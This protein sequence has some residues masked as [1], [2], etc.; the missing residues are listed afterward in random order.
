MKRERVLTLKKAAAAIIEA[1]SGSDLASPLFNRV[2]EAIGRDS[3]DPNSL[4]DAMIIIRTFEE[5]FEV[6]H[7][8]LA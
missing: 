6:Q 4:Y 3:L 8:A 5:A 2:R 1:V 7:F